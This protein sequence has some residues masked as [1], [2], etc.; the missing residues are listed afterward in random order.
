MTVA[1]RSGWSADNVR[2]TQAAEEELAKIATDADAFLA[3]LYD[4]EAKAG[5]IKLP[6]GSLVARIPGIRL[7]MWDGEFC[8]SIGLRWV[9]GT[10]QLPPHCLGHVGYAVVPWKRRL[11]YATQAVRELLPRARAVGLKYVEITTDVDN[12][13][14]Q[15]VVLAAGGVFVERFTKSVHYGGVEGFRFRID[16]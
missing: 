10:E 2:G 6:D 8:G 12:K 7:W 4:P 14:S 16:L 3:S 15:D 1:L 5:P 9:P 11:G 13:A